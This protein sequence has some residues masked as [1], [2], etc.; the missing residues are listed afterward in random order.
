MNNNN[1]TESVK[2]SMSQY[3]KNKLSK[4]RM[5]VIDGQ[6]S[7]D[8][9]AATIPMIPRFKRPSRALFDDASSSNNPSSSHYTGATS[10]ATSSRM[11]REEPIEEESSG[12]HQ[13]FASYGVSSTSPADN[14]SLGSAERVVSKITSTSTDLD[15]PLPGTRVPEVKVTYGRVKEVNFLEKRLNEGA[16]LT[17]ITGV[18]GIGKSHLAA[19]VCKAWQLT[20]PLNR[21]VIWINAATEW[22]LRVSYLEALQ[23]VLMGNVIE[24]ADDD[25][26]QGEIIIV[27]ELLHQQL[28]R[29][30]RKEEVK[31]AM[32]ER[33]RRAY[34]LRNGPRK[35]DSRD[36]EDEDESAEVFSQDSMDWGE[37]DISVEVPCEDE[38]EKLTTNTLA[39]LLWDALLQGV[40]TEY[41]WA[42]VVQNLPA[43]MGGI[44]GPSGIKPFFF[45]TAET[46]SEDWKQ[47]RIIFTTRHSSFSGVTCLGTI[48]S[49]SLTRLSTT[50]AMKMLIAS[51][52]FDGTRNEG[53]INLASPNK[54]EI[55]EQAERIAEKLVGP[56]YLDGSPLM[57]ATAVGQIITSKS[58]LRQYYKQ[59]KHQV[60]LALEASGYGGKV[61]TRVKRETAM[62]VCLEQAMDNA[63]A[64]GLADVL[65]AAAFVCG[66]GIPL[67][68]LG[69]DAARVK[70]LCDMNLL[71]HV[72]KDIYSMH[73]VHQR[74]AIDAII[75][76]V[77]DDSDAS[78]SASD[79]SEQFLCTP[80]HAVLALRSVMAG[81]LPENASTWQL[82]RTCIPHVEALRVHHDLLER[83]KQL[84]PNFNQAYYAEIVHSSAAVLQWAMKDRQSAF[85]GFNEALRL[86]RRLVNSVSST[87]IISASSGCNMKADLAAEISKTLSSMGELAEKP[88]E[89]RKYLKEAFQ[90]LSETFGEDCK[91]IDFMALHIAL[92]DVEV[93]LQNVSI[94]YDL[95]KK[96]L[97]L[98]FTIFG[99]NQSVFADEQKK[100]LASVLQKIGNLS[101]R[102]MNRHAEAELYLE[103]AVSLL[104]NFYNGESKEKRD[105]LA[106]ALETLGSVCHAQGR[107]KDARLHYRNALK[108]KDKIHPDKRSTEISN[109]YGT[110]S[111]SKSGRSVGTEENSES[112]YD[113]SSTGSSSEFLESDEFNHV[114]MSAP[115]P[116]DNMECALEIVPVDSATR[117]RA[118]SQR[119]IKL[120]KTLHRLGVMAWNL[121]S[122]KQA[123]DYFEKAFS[124]QQSGYG[125]DAKNE[126]IAI[127]LFSLGGLSNDLHNNQERACLYYKR[128][129]ECYHAARGKD[130][131]T[132]SI[133]QLLHAL[134]QSLQILKRPQEAKW[135]LKK[136]LDMKFALLQS[137]EDKNNH[138]LVATQL[139]LGKVSRDLNCNGEAKVYFKDALKGLYAMHGREAKNAE[140][141][142]C[143]T[144]LGGLS[145][146]SG[147]YAD[148]QQ[149]FEKCLD[150]KVYLYGH[151]EY[152]DDI[153]STLNNLGSLN[154]K[155]KNHKEAFRYYEQALEQYTKID[156]QGGDDVDEEEIKNHR[157]RTLHNMGLLSANLKKFDEARKF[158]SESLKIKADVFKDVKDSPEC[159]LTLTKLSNVEAREGKR[160]AAKYYQNQAIKRSPTFLDTHKAL[161]NKDLLPETP[162]EAAAM[163]VSTPN[164][165]AT[166]AEEMLKAMEFW[167]AKL[168]MG[169][170]NKTCWLNPFK[171]NKDKKDKDKKDKDKKKKKKKKKEKAKERLRKKYLE[172]CMNAA[173]QD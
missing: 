77:E 51:T 103:G 136:A 57:I 27:A 132:E 25:L 47:G 88:D 3:M 20:R 164:E 139:D 98:Y 165:D 124:M 173:I 149:Y 21:F 28:C 23:Q 138:D 35:D 18:G 67:K 166:D 45:P 12:Y 151:D 61:E 54:Q 131:Q 155:M 14:V 144:Q 62:S 50:V 75:T 74:T 86:Q 117:K 161:I 55:L 91:S 30:R 68:V 162:E 16:T 106:D 9:N 40:S 107:L 89:A 81:F 22:T 157:A 73:R 130:A 115:S 53:R 32:R 44:K 15:L 49:L 26:E 5:Q 114:R 71:S 116:D 90:I 113:D 92:A 122:L 168:E 96:G 145:Y 134:G 120:A 78:S 19:H 110:S 170:S 82:A 147:S 146:N 127:T 137:S 36:D 111:S 143:L 102:Q 140:L 163:M 46:P 59:L 141:A 65:S 94:A 11:V 142:S 41:E 69:G 31:E 63:H 29:Q 153:A 101:H 33:R 169:E 8:Y 80:D 150:M 167:K 99:H 93:K 13:S 58:T 76:N 85:A 70:K 4:S 156:E 152:N 119:D 39:H 38:A 66:E 148:A 172:E 97:E 128:A 17:C 95:Y 105:E 7:A 126:D 37:D 60:A 158:Y 42:I 109:K 133:A 10:H 123:E 79:E 118:S 108:I 83:K 112:Y 48:Y 34:E 2:N 6:T 1:E 154:A 87:E 125:Q 159:A 43:G 104:R 56:H 135:H 24:G 64:Q 160:E 100:F 171:R 84:S 121:G 52:V 72:D 129:L